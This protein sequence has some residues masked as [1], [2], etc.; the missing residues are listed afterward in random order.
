MKTL[1]RNGKIIDPANGIDREKLDLLIDDAKIVCIG[2]DISTNNANII[3]ATGL[4]I[5]PGLIDMHV[6]LREPGQEHKETIQT[7]TKSASKGGFTSVLAM[8]NTTPVADNP[9]V[10]RHILSQAKNVYANVYTVGSVTRGLLGKELVDIDELVNAGAIALSDDGKPVMN[11]ALMKDALIAC[12]EHNIPL[13]DH[14]EWIDDKYDGWVMNEG[15]VSKRLG[16]KGIPNSAEERMIERDIKLAEETEAH[17]HI[18]HVS[19]AGSVGLV[20]Q[21]KKKGINITAEATPHHFTLI[22]SAVEKHGANAKIN[23]PLRSQ[24]DVDAVIEGLKDGTIDVIATDHAPHADFE[25]AKGL[26][27]AP[28]GIVGLETCLSIVI[29]ELVNKGHLTLFDVIAKMTINPA[30]ILNLKKGTLSVGADAD[31]TIIDINK[32]WTVDPSKFESKGRNTPFA[33][34]KLKGLAVKTIL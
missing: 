7:G 16:V 31:I 25:K 2:K 30:R 33:G 27:E 1:I 17:L 34:W 13:I 8:A 32:E 22:D 29:T 5:I 11:P 15:E 24:K 3:D 18:A 6:H 21:A 28:F 9:Q 12:K 23:P 20:R 14:C 10:I 4:I 19:T 26:N